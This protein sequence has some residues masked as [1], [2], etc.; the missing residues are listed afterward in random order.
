MQ[1]L[2]NTDGTHR[3]L[4]LVRWPCEPI[5][6]SIG[7]FEG[8]TEVQLKSNWTVGKRLLASGS[9][10]VWKIRLILSKARLNLFNVWCRI[11]SLVLK[12]PLD[13]VMLHSGNWSD[14]K[15]ALWT[16]HFVDRTFW[17]SNW[18]PTEQLM[19]GW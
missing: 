13:D 11:V 6:L 17:G 14:I 15:M 2:A 12:E 19:K 8:L 3:I 5:I 1:F 10:T 7:H 4:Q 18:S 9:N 16:D